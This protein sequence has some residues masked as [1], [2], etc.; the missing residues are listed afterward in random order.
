[1][2]LVKGNVKDTLLDVLEG[3]GVL[4]FTNMSYY[5]L[6][7]LAHANSIDMVTY[8]T[9]ASENHVCT[10]ELQPLSDNWMDHLEEAK[11]NVKHFLKI[12]NSS[13]VQTVVLNHS[14]PVSASIAEQKLWRCLN[15][16]SNAINDKKVLPGTGK[17]EAW[18]AQ[19]L[20]RKAAAS[21]E[22][23]KGI[24]HTVMEELSQVF[25]DYSSLV[26]DNSYRE[27][28][29]YQSDDKPTLSTQKQNESATL[30]K[31]SFANKIILPK[32]FPQD[33]LNLLDK[34]A[35]V[36]EDKERHSQQNSTVLSQSNYLFSSDARKCGSY[37]SSCDEI[38]V[39]KNEHINYYD[40]YT[41]K[42]S[43]W[44]AALDV[45][46]LLSRLES[47]VITGIDMTSA[48]REFA[49]F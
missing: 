20:R 12:V 43:S 24:Q 23:N 16:L 32:Q 30:T 33:G 49:I 17:T 40:N 19:E 26:Q 11:S 18:C 8:I 45:V 21:L 41:S 7:A 38:D 2:I 44:E 37:H 9:D 27:Q 4:V 22:A 10:I 47:F 1:M 28:E 39:Y 35:H 46:S 34:N 36:A 42:V 31:N 13:D 15:F 3:A 6:S 29:Q 5:T 14:N 48:D 25:T